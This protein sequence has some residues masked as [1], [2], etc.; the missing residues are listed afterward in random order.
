MT[1][2]CKET[3]VDII[4]GKYSDAHIVFNLCEQGFYVKLTNPGTDNQKNIDM[5][6]NG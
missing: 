4:K 2:I 6:N 3:T 1:T 5:D